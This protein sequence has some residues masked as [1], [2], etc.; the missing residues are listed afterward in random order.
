MRPRLRPALLAVALLLPL[1]PASG[2]EAAPVA[3]TALPPSRAEAATW[4]V[5]LQLPSPLRAGAPASATIR[6]TA[7]AGHH[8]NLEYPAAF[9]PDGRA[10]ATFSGPRVALALTARRPCA[11]SPAE[12]CEV[13]LALPFTPGMERT[14]L[15]GMVLFSVCTAE[16]CLIERIALGAEAAR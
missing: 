12:A 3:V 9:K 6:L 13:T 14:R 16:R 15:S 10:T 1:A 2:A 11:G 7:R 4:T 5:A 8:V